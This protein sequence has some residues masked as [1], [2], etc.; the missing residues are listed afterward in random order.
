MISLGGYTVGGAYWDTHHKIVKGVKQNAERFLPTRV[1]LLD[2]G[3]CY[4]L[5]KEYTN[6]T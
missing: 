5:L 1:H 6:S 4:V 3:I 2:D